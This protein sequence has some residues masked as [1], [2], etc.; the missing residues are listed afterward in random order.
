MQHFDP[1]TTVVNQVNSLNSCIQNQRVLVSRD[2][3]E[4]KDRMEFVD[5]MRF[6]D[7]MPG[8]FFGGRCLMPFEHYSS[9][10]RL[11]FGEQAMQKY[12]PKGIP[13][14][15]IDAELDEHYYLKSNLSVVAN[16]ARVQVWIL[17]KVDMNYLPDKV[18]KSV[19]E[20]VMFVKEE[21][22][23]FHESEIEFIVDQYNKWDKFKIDLVE[24][25]FELKEIEKFMKNM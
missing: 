5:I 12:Y 18:L 7:L 21:D 2:G 14:E 4:I 10:R 15:V 25:M 20:K 8:N 9:L 13:A 3:K 1:E 19:F 23:P 22:R 17:D 24:R 16:S 11:Y 6:N